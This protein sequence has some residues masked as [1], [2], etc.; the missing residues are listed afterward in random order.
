MNEK[1]T[2]QITASG[3]LDAILSKELGISRSQL[4]KDIK[5]GSVSVNGVIIDHPSFN[6]KGNEE[7]IYAPVEKVNTGIEKP[8]DKVEL[9][10]V[11]KDDDIVVINKPRGMVVHPAPGHSDD[12]LVNY[13]FDEDESF[14]YDPKDVSNTRPGIVH[15]IDKD[16]SGLLVVAQNPQTEA[17]LQDEIREREFHRFY[18]A[19][20]YGNVKDKRFKI[21]APLTKPN[22]SHRKAEVDIYKGREAVTHCTLLG[23]NGKVSLLKCSLETGR[24]HQIRAHLAY[25]GYPIVGDT[26]YGAKDDKVARLGQALHAYQLSIIHPRTLKRTVFY[27]P[28]DSYFKEL[29]N[30]FFR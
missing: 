13:L 29:L 30:Y 1:K 7:V 5:V 26:L 15:R 23:N 16:T 25:I 10:I 6:L 8:K 11:Y 14:D 19:L 18:L 9:D 12:T 2:I 20:V 27:A 22:H 4:A 24:T 28:L 3:R 21:D 17:T